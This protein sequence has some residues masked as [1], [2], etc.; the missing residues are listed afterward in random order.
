[1]NARYKRWIAAL[2]VFLAWVATLS[3]MAVVSGRRPTH[4]HKVPAPP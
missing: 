3:T 1:M 2:V 4:H